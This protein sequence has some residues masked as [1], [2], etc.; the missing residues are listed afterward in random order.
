MAQPNLTSLR[1]LL[2]DAWID[3][4]VFGAKPLHWLGQ[5]QKK[6]ANNIW[7]PYT[8]WLAEAVLASKNISFDSEAL[9]NRLKSRNDF[10]P[11]L[12]EMESAIF[13]A[14]QG[15]AVM[16]E[17]T[18]PEKGPDFRADW[19]D[20]PY[21]LEVRTVG[22]SEDEDRRES[23]T[24]EIFEKLNVTPSSY[25]AALTV[26]DKYKAGSGELRHA[27]AAIL[28]SLD[29]LKERGARGGDAVLRGRGRSSASAA[30]TKTRRQ[31]LGYSPES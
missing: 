24:N 23:V 7:V 3:A 5:W 19:E 1:K 30:G 22:F 27:I 9:A 10:G 28:N 11:T 26:G 20:V 8:E 25:W 15:F 16:F 13:L 6:D 29:A 12:A 31:T 18:A 4:E 17:P 2:G 21:F 14:G